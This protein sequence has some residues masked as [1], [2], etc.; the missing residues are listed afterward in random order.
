MGTQGSLSSPSSTIY[1]S[2]C[3]SKESTEER[4]DTPPSSEY[5]R[6]DKNWFAVENIKLR[7]KIKHL[8]GK[9]EKIRRALNVKCELLKNRQETQ[10]NKNFYIELDKILS[11]R[12]KGKKFKN[13]YIQ[14]DINFL[15][16]FLKTWGCYFEDYDIKKISSDGE[17]EN[18][19]RKR[20]QKS[21]SE[22][23]YDKNI[24]IKRND[25]NEEGKCEKKKNKQNFSSYID[26]KYSIISKNSNSLKIPQHIIYKKNNLK[27]SL[28]TDDEIIFIKEITEDVPRKGKHE[29]HHQEEQDMQEDVQIPLES[30]PFARTS[31]LQVKGDYKCNGEGAIGQND[32]QKVVIQLSDNR[33][34]GY[35]LLDRGYVISGHGL[36]GENLKKMRRT[37]DENK[38]KSY[39]MHK[40]NN[41]HIHDDKKSYSSKIEEGY[42]GN[43]CE[44]EVAPS[45]ED[46]NDFTLRKEKFSLNFFDTSAISKNDCGVLANE[47]DSKL[48][49][50][51]KKKKKKNCTSSDEQSI[52]GKVVS[53]EEMKV[54]QKRGNPNEGDAIHVKCRRNKLFFKN[55]SIH[56]NENDNIINQYMYHYE[57]PIGKSWSWS[58]FAEIDINKQNKEDFRSTEKNANERRIIRDDTNKNNNM[59]IIY[60]SSF[61]SKKRNSI[62]NTIQHVFVTN[63]GSSGSLFNKS[64]RSNLRNETLFKG[65]VT[66]CDNGYTQ[67]GKTCFNLTSKS[68]EENYEKISLLSNHFSNIGTWCCQKNSD[69]M[70]Y[71]SYFMENRKM[72]SLPQYNSSKYESVIAHENKKGSSCNWSEYMIKKKK[73]KK[74]SVGIC[75][76]IPLNEG[77]FSL[78]GN[79]IFRERA[80]QS[81][82]SKIAKKKKKKEKEKKTNEKENKKDNKNENK[83]YDGSNNSNKNGGSNGK[84]ISNN[85]KS[86][87]PSA[88]SLQ[89]E[90]E[91]TLFNSEKDYHYIKNMDDTNKN[92]KKD[93]PGKEVNLLQHKHYHLASER[94]QLLKNSN[95][96]YYQ[97]LNMGG[98]NEDTTSLNDNNEFSLSDVEK[99][100]KSSHQIWKRSLQHKKKAFLF[101]L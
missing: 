41:I 42:A 91:T 51:G 99:I 21:I 22:I 23:R 2:T 19:R 5:K 79:I 45:E 36:P 63:S 24:Q 93:T 86:V 77:K 83:N 61:E 49:G 31:S 20:F 18:L 37:Y 71:S 7:N 43:T 12:K 64:V 13:T 84:N 39:S 16:P 67:N 78:R 1:D 54:Q 66:H 72:W 4:D 74:L 89:T 56:H 48:Q 85:L 100:E 96:N 69:K 46:N 47:I 95:E 92:E 58:N 35:P 55:N 25:L 6:S 50:T 33:Q 44:M 9:C 70:A 38:Y 26:R 28:Y 34:R 68:E 27:Y 32:T 30:D 52:H 82:S 14:T 75:E 76:A 3:I 87:S 15:N 62:S 53:N 90:D 11:K 97:L 59:N 60:C 98:N 65:E 40:S 10:P 101:Y 81:A 88:S 57:K 17:V 8:K 73:K 29:D 94:K 80:P